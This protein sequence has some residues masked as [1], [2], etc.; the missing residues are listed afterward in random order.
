MK[1]LIHGIN[2]SPEL[3]GIG[4]YSGE[5]AQWLAARGH[6][7]RVVTAPPYY[8]EWRVGAGYSAFKYRTEDTRYK[9]QGSRG[10]KKGARGKVQEARDNVKDSRQK[11]RTEKHSGSLVVYR[12][13]LWV[14][15]KPSGFKRLVH[16]ASFALS[17]LPV[18][19]RHI[20]WKPD[21]VLVIEPPLMCAPAALLV[22]R[23]C[24]ARA[25]LHV[26]DFE[27]DAAFDLGILPPGR[28]RSVVLVIERRL[29][30]AFSRV[31]TIS[32]N[33]LRT[34]HAKGVDAEKAVLFPN[35]VDLDTIYPLENASSLRA[36]LEISMD[37]IVALY[38]GNMGEKQ[39]LEV[40]L[41][42]AVLQAQGTRCKIQDASGKGQGSRGKG[43]GTRSKGQGT[44]SK[45]QEARGKVKDKSRMEHG[46]LEPCDLN[47]EPDVLFVLC[48]D[49]A[50]RQRLRQT[51]GE[52]DNVMWLPLQPLAR[53]NDLLNLADIHLLPQRADAADLVMPSK[54]TGMLASGRPVVA[55]VHPG[56]QVASVL[57][58]CGLVTA[59][60][61]AGEF[62]QA[63]L[64]LA[65]D[66][67][68][69]AEYGKM[70][71]MYAVEYLD[72]QGIMER[73]EKDLV[74]LASV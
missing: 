18:M 23:L 39:G 9:V 32:V 57:A 19:L 38:S 2:F 7:I 47:L 12:C 40:V 25:W 37:K 16:L 28:M 43:Q 73:F 11:G 70:A 46:E 58:G 31:S 59:P 44:R 6:E 3:T 34:L 4:K 29:M 61:D 62:L 54:L 71:R 36:E 22:A 35:W 27:V 8:P 20:F 26:Q 33:M 72:K 63:V 49:G 68:L 64:R 66:A 10:K 13:P 24:G 5:M 55:T 50:A 74:A 51:Y 45:G 69:R 15:A 65:L 67:S 1:I 30:R 17:S 14:P 21:V 56:T 41:D 48:G 53:L 52:L 42:A 60:G